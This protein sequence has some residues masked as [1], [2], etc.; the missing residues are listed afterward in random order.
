VGKASSSKKVARASRTARAK[1][2]RQSTASLAWPVT[3]GA[4]VLLGLA[5][6]LVSRDTGTAEAEPPVRGD[7][8][9]A[10]L[11]FDICGQFLPP[12]AEFENVQGLHSHGDGLIHLH[13]QSSAV[14]GKKATLAK[15][16]EL[17]GG[18]LTDTELKPPGGD[19][20]GNGDRCGDKPGKVQV[21]VDGKRVDRPT[22]V[23]LRDQQRITVAFLP[24]GAEIPEPPSAAG[25]ASPSDLGGQPGVQPELPPQSV[26][27]GGSPL[28]SGGQP[29]PSPPPA[30]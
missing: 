30:Q 3:L 12:D 14:T 2:R 22:E 1:G 23:R 8:W 24:E 5:L 17:A 19:T 29:S 7:H 6:V 27:P 15:Y 26:P 28:P 4:L 11:G 18:K 25:L 9:H 21:A 13:P 10:A 16:I 20:K